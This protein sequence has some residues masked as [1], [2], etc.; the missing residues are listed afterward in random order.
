MICLE[1]NM[2]EFWIELLDTPES[3]YWASLFMSNNVSD[4][5]TFLNSLNE[6]NMYPLASF[7]TNT[8]MCYGDVEDVFE[9]ECMQT[10]AA[11][12]ENKQQIY[13]EHYSKN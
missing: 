7:Q 9:H 3:I 10:K 6:I 1:P 8:I 12:L 2:E 13:L 11:W 5:P 4:K